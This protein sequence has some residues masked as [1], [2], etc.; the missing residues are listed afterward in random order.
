MTACRDI[1]NQETVRVVLPRAKPLPITGVQRS[2]VQCDAMIASRNIDEAMRRT[3]VSSAQLASMLSK[4][5]QRLTGATV[6]KWRAPSMEQVPNY[7]WLLRMKRHAPKVWRELRA[8]E[9]LHDTPRAV[10]RPANPAAF[11]GIAFGDFLRALQFEP[12][13]VRRAGGGLIDAVRTCLEAA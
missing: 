12:A 4:S 3:G 11:V 10:T 7:K 2:D 8:I 5:G 1:T 9:D 6:A 13:K